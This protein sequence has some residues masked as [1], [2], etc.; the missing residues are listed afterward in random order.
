MIQ[1]QKAILAV[2][3]FSMFE[4]M[5]QN[6]LNCIDGFRDASAILLS[7]NQHVLNERFCDLQLAINVLKHGRGRSYDELVKKV[8]ACIFA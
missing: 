3:M 5:L 8:N 7:Q 1:L 4:A 2:G 6:C